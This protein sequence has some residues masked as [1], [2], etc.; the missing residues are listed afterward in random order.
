MI[1]KNSKD[2]NSAFALNIPLDENMVGKLIKLGAP[3]LPLLVKD[4]AAD[5]RRMARKLRTFYCGHRGHVTAAMSAD[6]SSGVPWCPLVSAGVSAGVRRCPQVQNVRSVRRFCEKNR[7]HLRP[8][9]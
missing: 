9:P 8:C 7:G 4:M 1:N 6:L 3:A 2:P 5:G